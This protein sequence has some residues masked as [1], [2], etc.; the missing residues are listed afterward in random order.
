[1]SW[2]SIS[3]LVTKSALRKPATRLYPFETREPYPKTRG[4]IR[5]DHA[6]NTCTFC[7]ICAHKCPTQAIQVNKKEKI[8]AI[9]HMRCIL[10][11]NCTESCPRNCL[12]MAHTPHAPMLKQEVET[13]RGSFEPPA[14]LAAGA[15][16]GS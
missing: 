5:F 12:C 2:F 3:A 10:C 6:A 1:M 9:D 15:T 7:T 13:F 11:S 14:P 8:W 4:H 16:T